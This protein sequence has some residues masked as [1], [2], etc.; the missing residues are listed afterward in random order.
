MRTVLY[1]KRFEIVLHVTK[2][3]IHNF[4]R[5]TGLFVRIDT[6]SKNYNNNTLIQNQQPIIDN[7][8]NNKND[9]ILLIGPSYP[10]KTHLMLNILPRIPD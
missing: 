5:K 9:Q 4:T 2:R 7:V 10:G 6:I 3:E 1:Y 8:N